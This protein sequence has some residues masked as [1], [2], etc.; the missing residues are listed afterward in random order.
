MTAATQSLWRRIWARYDDT[1]LIKTVFFGM[2]GGVIGTLYIDYQELQRSASYEVPDGARPVPVLPA[3]APNDGSPQAPQ[4]IRPD[5]VTTPADAHRASMSIKLGSEGVLQLTGTIEPETATLFVS[6]IDKIGEYVKT[7]SL[8]S[9]GGFLQSA[10]TMGALIREKGY[11]TKI[12][13][14]AL[15]ASAC[16]LI[17]A[18]GTNRTVDKKAAFGLHQIYTAGGDPLSAAEAMSEAQST[19]A[20]ITR[21]LEGMGVEP[22]VWNFALETPPSQLYYLSSDEL[23]NFNITTD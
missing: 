18:S 21:Y 7:I 17:F 15:C 3:A 5:F 19:T 8:D 20:R 22:A 23:R 6:E 16:P 10:L 14:G 9:P 13:D 12:A 1:K 11:D 4:T 2:V